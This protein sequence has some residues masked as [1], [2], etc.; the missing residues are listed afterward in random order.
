MNIQ[1]IT[2]LAGLTS[3]FLEVMAAGIGAVTK[4]YLTRANANAEAH[5]IGTISDAVEGQD[6]LVH[7][8]KDGLSVSNAKQR[9]LA[10]REDFQGQKRQSQLESVTSIAADE[11][12]AEPS[13]EVSK[14]PVDPDWISHFFNYAQDVSSEHMQ[15]LWGKVL[16]REVIKPKS[17]SMR[18]LEVLRLLTR[19]EAELFEKLSKNRFTSSR[20]CFLPNPGLR[21]TEA[22]GV[23]YSDLLTMREAGLLVPNDG[24]FMEWNTAAGFD[25]VYEHWNYRYWGETKKR[26][27]KLPI[28]SF[29]NAGSEIA[30]LVQA[31]FDEK[32]ADKVVAA[33]RSDCVILKRGFIRSR[34]GEDAICDQIVDLK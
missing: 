20:H 27:I 22:Y 34:R 29:T 8:E 23:K 21:L 13:R 26:G 4:P 10:M 14:E 16:A 19:E 30:Q 15:A 1:D 31:E 33:I 11:L 17:F 3:K 28:I 6:A 12:K 5:K 7:Y 32:L 2:G 25:L 9:R 24:L 18:S